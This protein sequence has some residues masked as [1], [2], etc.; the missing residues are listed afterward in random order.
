MI[1]QNRLGFRRRV[2]P[3]PLLKKSGHD[4][5]RANLEHVGKVLVDEPRALVWREATCLV[6]SARRYNRGCKRARWRQA[7]AR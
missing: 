4:R 5:A 3:D 1:T 2:I 6:M 7:I